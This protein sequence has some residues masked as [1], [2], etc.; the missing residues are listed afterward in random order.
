MRLEKP[1][2]HVHFTSGSRRARPKC[3]FSEKKNGI[4]RSQIKKIEFKQLIKEF[5]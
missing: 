2:G 5:E 3:Q 4:K 1:E